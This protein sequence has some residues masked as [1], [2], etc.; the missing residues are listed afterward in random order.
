LD[1]TTATG[2]LEA[3]DVTSLG[4]FSWIAAQ[5]KTTAGGDP[6]VFAFKVVYGSEL[7]IAEWYSAEGGDNFYVAAGAYTVTFDTETGAVTITA[8]EK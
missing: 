3:T 4:D 5:N 2:T 7:G 8:L 6:A 1:G